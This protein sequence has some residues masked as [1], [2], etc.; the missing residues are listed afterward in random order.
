MKKRSICCSIHVVIAGLELIAERNLDVSVLTTTEDLACFGEAVDITG[1]EEHAV[2]KDVAYASE[3]A[4]VESAVV[5]LE[6]SVRLAAVNR[7][8]L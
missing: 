6:R 7:S 4:E 5:I 1:V 8:F 3:N 2:G